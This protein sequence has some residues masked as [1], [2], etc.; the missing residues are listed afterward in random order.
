MVVPVGVMWCLPQTSGLGR[1]KDLCAGGVGSRP[2]GWGTRGYW[3]RGQSCRVRSC[4]A[5]EVF[6]LAVNSLMKVVIHREVGVQCSDCLYISVLG[7]TE[8]TQFLL[9]SRYSY[10]KTSPDLS[11]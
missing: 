6:T 10:Y 1:K 8:A 4:R 11:R 9:Q 3:R 5:W 7:A 2:G